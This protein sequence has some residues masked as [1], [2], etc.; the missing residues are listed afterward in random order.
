M[1]GA[2]RGGET[3]NKEEG[4]K[5]LPPGDGEEEARSEFPSFLSSRAEPLQSFPQNCSNKT[6]QYHIS[7]NHAINL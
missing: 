1:Y 2:K 5:R 7:P 3:E 6:S 4:I